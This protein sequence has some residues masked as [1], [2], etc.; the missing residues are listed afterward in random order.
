MAITPLPNELQLL[1][2]VAKGD[3]HAFKS[4]YDHYHEN[5]YAFSL[6]YLKSEADAEEVVQETFLKLWIQGKAL[7][8]IENLQNYLRTIAGNKSLD[9]LRRRAKQMKVS[10]F[11]DTKESAESVE[12]QLFHNETEEAILLKEFKQLL[13]DAVGQLPVQQKLVY[14]LCKEQGLKNDE[15]A[16]QLKLSPLTVR[17]HMKLALRFVREYIKK[18]SDETALLAI[19]VIL[20][21]F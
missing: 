3:E 13:N 10:S 12:N 15:V 16:K 17:T 2:Q 18:R 19:M 4:I 8:Q 9:M 1:A 14:Q 20:K 11:D 7:E 21:I 6:W 5:V